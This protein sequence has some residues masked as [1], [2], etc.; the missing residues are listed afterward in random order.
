MMASRRLVALLLI[1]LLSLPSLTGHAAMHPCISDCSVAQMSM[2]D[3]SAMSG[4]STSKCAS[5]A[6]LPAVPPGLAVSPEPLASAPV[7]AM[8][9][10][11]SAPPRRPPRS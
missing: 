3:D 9:E 10:Y 1:L 8:V 6:T 4:E 2:S 5:C 11:I 7:L